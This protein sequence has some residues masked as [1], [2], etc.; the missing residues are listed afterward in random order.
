MIFMGNRRTEQGKDAVT[1]SLSHIPLIAMHGVHHEVQRRINDR[2]GFFGIEAFNES[3]GAFEVSKERGDR[4]AL[5]IRTAARFQGSLLGPD[6]LGQV[7]RGVARGRRTRSE[8]SGLGD[9]GLADE[10][11]GTLPA[12]LRSGQILR[13]AARTALLT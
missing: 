3:G 12:E 6:A 1:Q 10:W 5:A 2:S 7:G 11:S 8:R 9:Q 4:L 13:P